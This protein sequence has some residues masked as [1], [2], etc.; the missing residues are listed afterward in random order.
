MGRWEQVM[1]GRGRRAALGV[2][3][4]ALAMAGG[5]RSSAA[6]PP[7]AA[8]P[9]DA[10]AAHAC[11]ASASATRAASYAA[12]PEGVSGLVADNPAHG[13]GVRFSA[14]GTVILPADAGRDAWALRLTLLRHGRAGDLRDAAGPAPLVLGDRVETSRDPRLSEWF[15][16]GPKGL[17]HGLDLDA[18]TPAAL[19]EFEFGLATTL[20]PKVSPDH[21]SIR[22]LDAA[23][24]TVLAW[25]SLRVVDAGG[26]EATARWEVRPGG[27]DG[28]RILALTIDATQLV[29]PILV[30]GLVTSPK[31]AAGVVDVDADVEA[32]AD[33]ATDTL[34]AHGFDLLVAPSN[35]LCSGAEVVPGAGP[36]PYLS[37]TY[38]I[39]DATTAGDPP[40]PSCQVNVSRSVWF[41]FTPSTGGL[42]TFSLCS[43]APTATTVADTVL[44]IYSA[45]GSCSGFSEVGGGCDDDSCS[46][47]DT[48]SAINSLQLTAGTTYYVVAWQFGSTAPPAGGAAV[49]LRVTKE[50]TPPTAPPNDQCPGAQVIPAAGP[51]PYLTTTVPDITGATTA[52]D[53]QAPSCQ[54]LVSRSV[55]YAFTPAAT[56][57]YTFSLCSDAPTATTVDDTV[58]AIYGSNGTCSG[59]LELAGGCND[60]D[61]CG[62]EPLQSSLEGLTLTAGTTYYVVAWQFDTPPPAAGNTAVQVRVTQSLVPGNDTCANA[63]PLALDSPVDGTTVGAL[64]T[65][66]LPSTAT[67]C[68]AGIGNTAF[69][70]APGRDVVYR[71]TAPAAGA[72]SFRVT[73]YTGT[74]D[75]VVYAAGDC[76]AVGPP[77]N[78]AG[79]LGAANR[80]SSV[81]GAEEARCVALAGGQMVYVYVDEVTLSTGG[82]FTVEVNACP[83]E[84]DTTASSSTNNTTATANPFVCGIEGSIAVNDVDFFSIGAPAAGSRVFALVDGVAANNNDFDL[85]V[86]NATDTL[87]FDN[88]D[89][90]TQFGPNSPNVAGTPLGGAA[91]YLRVNWHG[92]SSAEPYRLY[93]AVQ[94]AS[95]GATPEVEPNNSIATATGGANLYFSGAL[96]ATTDVDIFSFTAAA[97]DLIH[98]GLD[99]DPLRNNTPF[100][101]ALAL[102][103]AAG[104]TLVSVNDPDA[105]SSTTTGAGNLLAT[106]PFSPAESLAY[107]ARAAGTYYARVAYA[108]G[109]PGDYLL[110]VARNCRIGPP[111][112]LGVQLSDAPD[113]V[114][115]GANVVY[116]ATVTNL[117]STAA[118]A[119]VLTDT[120]PGGTTFVSAVPSQGSCTGTGP[121]VCALGGL[122]AAASATVQITLTAPGAPA[123]IVDTARV[124]SA[125]IDP[126]PGN[127]TASEATTV[128]QADSDGDGVPDGSDCAPSDPS[129]W[130]VPGP[131]QLV[132]FPGPDTATIQWSPPVLPGG[133]GLVYDL[134]RST[135]PASLAAAT[136]IVKGVTAT[137]AGDATDTDAGFFYLVRARNA[138]G[139]NLGTDSS[140]TPRTAPACQ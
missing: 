1:K 57:S 92:F 97:G 107:R 124:T 96:A 58:L 77:G 105:A 71:F 80:N 14:E 61:S 25:N 133:P 62:L 74:G 22:F 47:S 118:A 46:V 102:L 123:T 75:A 98:L 85:R 63:I 60:D 51:F 131:A 18:T 90:D 37:G 137:T 129:A 10:P 108:S 119:V 109:I 32:D 23:G 83:S 27:A 112:D 128:G 17:E 12:V 33:A 111:A 113:P 140:G 89:N 3:V 117:G 135:D 69:T 42:Y 9:P 104:S 24:R 15:L 38:D 115:P 39:T 94:P 86:T 4:V 93:A 76:P 59:L 52:G 26:R 73:N 125:T 70:T 8:A 84:S 106:T 81:P 50:A 34:T 45:A 55:W 116:T 91:A 19:L 49:Q 130:A 132:L 72:Y 82:G 99:L 127:D 120:L 66:E 36:F 67:A 65:Y 41:R 16:N 35:D 6:T 136:C 78:I 40:A 138:C 29:A 101:G 134:L 114:A 20:A 95:A 7:D 56:A 5:A 21:R 110:S 30:R 44:A 13:F 28:D 11:G 88:N 87:E 139:S 126:N 43:D 68:F 2:V 31:H 54:G 64:D 48:Q 121:V 100:D 122:A 79:C 53:P 103:D